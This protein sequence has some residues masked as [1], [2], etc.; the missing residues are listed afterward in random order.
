[1]RPTDVDSD[2]VIEKELV[3][4]RP[5]ANFVDL[6]R[7]LIVKMGFHHILGKDVSNEIASPSYY[8]AEAHPAAPSTI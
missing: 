3:G 1:M 4:M 8:G 7:P 6:P 2:V 5:K